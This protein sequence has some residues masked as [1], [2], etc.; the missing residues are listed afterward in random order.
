MNDKL[1]K[2]LDDITW[3]FLNRNKTMKGKVMATTHAEKLKEILNRCKCGIHLAV[4]EHRN[5]YLTAGQRLEELYTLECPPKI[6]D[7]VKKTMI[8]TDTIIELQFYP[9]TPVGSY[10]VYH[11]DLDM[12][13][14]EA[15]E[16]LGRP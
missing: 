7:N 12:A 10:S 14:D 15:L 1:I 8:E 13:L 2:K 6:D 9:D 3:S 5:Y 4:N 16:C 11:H